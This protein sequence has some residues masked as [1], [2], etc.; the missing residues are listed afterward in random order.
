[1]KK[2]YEK[3][4]KLASSLASLLETAETNLPKKHLTNVNALNSDVE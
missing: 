2:R 3:I 1:M 4:E